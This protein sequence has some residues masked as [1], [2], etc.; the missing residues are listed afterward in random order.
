LF[1]QSGW[2]VRSHLTAALNPH[3]AVARADAHEKPGTMA[4]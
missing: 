2:L 1:Y 4:G 3:A